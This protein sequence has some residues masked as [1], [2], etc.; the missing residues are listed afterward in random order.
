[1]LVLDEPTSNLDPAARRELA[2]VLRGA[3]RDDA[4]GHPRPA[5]RA[6][7]VRPGGDPRR[8][9]HRR[10]RADR[11][12]LADAELLAAHRLELPRGFQVHTHPHHHGPIV[13]AHPHGHEAGAETVHEHYPAVAITDV[14]PGGRDR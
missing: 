13:H 5:L 6:G 8:G 12:I 2:D 11:D 7:A 14:A 1:M 3:G 9:A 4:G 10:G